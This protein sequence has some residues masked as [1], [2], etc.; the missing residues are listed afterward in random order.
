[1]SKGMPRKTRKEQKAQEKE[2]SLREVIQQ[3]EQYIQAF[4][5]ATV[6]EANSF[7]TWKSLKP[8]SDEEAVHILADPAL[9]RRI[10][11]SRACYR[12]KNKNVPPLK[13]KTRIVC[14][15]NQDPDLVNLTRQAPTPTRTS[16]ML[17]YIIFVSGA[18]GKAFGSEGQWYLWCGDASTAF[19]QGTPDWSERSGKLYLKAP[20]DP[21]II[22]AKVF[23]TS[24]TRS[25]ATYM[26]Y[27]MLLL[28]GLL[29]LAK[30][31][32]IWV[33]FATHSIR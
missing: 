30:G 22:R 13:A 16:E 28:H 19:L 17:V 26:V 1:M 20:R 8:I 2:I 29:K 10:I 27:P 33:S 5:E 18:N 12:D 14:R 9:K 21:I 11:T 15:G 3:S 25:P 4:V 6:K 23:H 31:C 32:T 7:T 24:C